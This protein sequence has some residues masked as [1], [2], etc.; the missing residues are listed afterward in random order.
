[1]TL[2]T[3]TALINSKIR[4]KTPKV[5]KV[6]HADVEQAL[7]D[8]I[9]NGY[10]LEQII[11][12]VDDPSN[13]IISVV[14]SSSSSY[15]DVLLYFKISGKSCHA[16]GYFTI[17]TTGTYDSQ[18][19]FSFDDTL[20]EPKIDIFSQ[21]GAITRYGSVVRLKRVGNQIQTVGACIPY[22]KYYIDAVYEIEN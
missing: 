11:D 15:F 2:A 18:P 16:K 12:G 17:K 8:E 4:N 14:S 5:L 10:K 1:M 9:F 19:L 7:A 22:E 3:I 6:E 20:Y 21:I 13:T